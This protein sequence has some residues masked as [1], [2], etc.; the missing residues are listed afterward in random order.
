MMINE[1]TTL[2]EA[3]H[4]WPVLESFLAEQ[5][6][7][8]PEDPAVSLHSIVFGQ[9]EEYYEDHAILPEQL[10]QLLLDYVEALAAFLQLERPL[11]KLSLLPG[12][13]KDGTPEG[14]ARLDFHKGEIVALVGPTGAG[15]SRLL[16]DIEYLAVG[17][18]PT[19]RSILI[20][21]EAPD[22]TK[23]FSVQNK[24]VAELSQNMN[25]VMDLTVREFLELHASSRMIENAE[26]T[27]Q[28][29]IETAVNL[30]G[31]PF[32]E[33]TNIT[34]LSGGQSRSLMIADT[35]LLSPSPIVLIDEL[36]NAG[37]DRREALKLLVAGDKIVLMATHD[38]VLALMANR[39]LVIQNGGIA[40]VVER[41]PEE[42][43]VLEALLVQDGRLRDLRRQLRHG[44]TLS[45]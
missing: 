19:G 14:Y 45:Y 10:W 9:T 35:A 37:I 15:K 32:N 41:S 18:S 31:E 3:L 25:F 12:R 34:A 17:D 21:D 30:A 11:E 29:I 26:A 13:H 24:L 27:V 44:E 7:V 43:T 22:L 8:L 23:R 20:N 6:L 40:K 33:D 36:E 38:P 1:Q 39:R 2:Q 28:R 16:A 42:Q 5:A 4:D